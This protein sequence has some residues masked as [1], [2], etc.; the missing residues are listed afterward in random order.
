MSKGSKFKIFPSGLKTG[1]RVVKDGCVYAGSIEKHGELLINDIL[2]PKEEK[3]IGKRH[4]MIQYNKGP[5]YLD[6]TRYFIKDMGEGLGTFIRIKSPVKF[7]SSF[8]FSFGDSHMIT[9]IENS[10][11]TLKF[12][13]GPKTDH[14][15]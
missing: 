9:K 8:I 4:F 2:L 5:H 3:G 14:K 6:K 13:E 12:I 7:S 1:K 15:W 11:L 10:F